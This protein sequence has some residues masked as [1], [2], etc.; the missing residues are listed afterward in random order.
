MLPRSSPGTKALCPAGHPT[1][2]SCIM[3][4]DLMDT[5]ESR[6]PSPLHTVGAPGP[7]QAAVPPLGDCQ[8]PA[9]NPSQALC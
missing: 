5:S 9:I 6:C 7:L 4:H 8:P 3:D 2:L 1:D